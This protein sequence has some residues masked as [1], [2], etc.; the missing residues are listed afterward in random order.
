MQDIERI[1]AAVQ[2][3][4]Q[5]INDM[6]LWGARARPRLRMVPAM[7]T[8]HPSTPPASPPD[9]AEPATPPRPRGAI[10]QVL[11]DGAWTA[12]VARRDAGAVRL[13][14]PAPPSPR[15]TSSPDDAPTL[16]T[17][18]P[19][20]ASGTV[21][22]PPEPPTPPYVPASTE[23]RGGSPR[24]WPSRTMPDVQQVLHLSRLRSRETDQRLSSQVRWD[25]YWHDD[26]P[27]IGGATPVA[28]HALRR[29]LGRGWAAV[30]DLSSDD[31]LRRLLTPNHSRT[32]YPFRD[33][34]A[35][36]GAVHSWHHCTAEQLAAFAGN[37]R[38][39]A[40]RAFPLL[41][42]IRAGALQL[43]TVQHPGVR[44]GP[45]PVVFSLRGDDHLIQKAIEERLTPLEQ[46]AITGGGTWSGG[47]THVRHNVLATELGLRASEYLPG[48]EAVM[49]E[50]YS[51]LDALAG[52]GAR[53][54]P[55]T[56][57]RAADMTLVCANGIHIAIEVTA[58]A[59]ANIQSKVDHW[60]ETLDDPTRSL[61]ATGLIVI[62]LLAPKPGEQHKKAADHV[63]RKVHAAVL[64]AARRHH[65]GAGVPTRLRV[66][67]ADWREWFPG[68]HLVS[69]A[70]LRL[71]ANRPVRLW[72]DDAVA[73]VYRKPS[74]YVDVWAPADFL[75]DTSEPIAGANASMLLSRVEALRLL[76]QTAHWYRDR[77]DVRAL[78]RTLLASSGITCA[79]EPSLA[80][81][82]GAARDARLPGR[83][84]GLAAFARSPATDPPARMT[85]PKLRVTRP[86]IDTR[87]TIEQAGMAPDGVVSASR[88]LLEVSIGRLT[89]WQLIEAASQD[90]ASPLRA[91]PL[92]QLL[93]AERDSA[94]AKADSH[95]RRLAIALDE[96]IGQVRGK[97]VSWL[98]KANSCG[99]RMVAWRS[100]S[101]QGR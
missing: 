95:L 19:Q 69:D 12:T 28:D 61:E 45:W 49:G 72:S 58:T 44:R 30:E 18:A 96:D 5:A 11:V 3:H 82:V 16:P 34:L 86:R 62:F 50:R 2:A 59:G 6:F 79:G 4:G 56:T 22:R 75:R 35:T 10:A 48:V 81:G 63:R 87:A 1:S 42:A 84:L 36:L 98:V 8:H 39:L 20:Q 17:A 41:L 67:V 32:P 80:D 93:L 13:E 55:V 66:G 97:D 90:P 38:L 76:G 78:E 37:H 26:D 24:R 73:S 70:F 54:N 99:R 68:P 23:R 27:G 65:V 53:L 29:L 101:G 25:P 92:V 21:S 46:H 47:R 94:P 31:A 74:D 7:E 40:G 51:S 60:F 77:I 52:S 91:I 89:P 15:G 83:L 71:R 14:T 64:D 57:A 43:Q 100:V 9:D 85:T 88:A 33:H